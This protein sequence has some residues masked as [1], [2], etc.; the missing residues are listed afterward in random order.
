MIFVGDIVLND[1]PGKH[2]KADNDPFKSF[3]PVFRQADLVVGNLEC[4]VG[5]TGKAE[6]K[7]FV[8]RA[9]PRSVAHNQKIL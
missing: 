4:V 5:T 6:D 2:I 3:I 8:L 7:P 9:N 1:L